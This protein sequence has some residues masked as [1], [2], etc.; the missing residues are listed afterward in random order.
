MRNIKLLLEYD[1]TEYVGWQI[2]DN[3]RSVQGELEHALSTVTQQ[4]VRL[5]G[6][7]RTDAGVHAR[8]QVAHFHTESSLSAEQLK[9]GVNALVADDLRVL[10]AQEVSMEFHARYSAKQRNYE[11]TIIRKP[12][13][14]LR[15]VSW[16]VSYA[17][18]MGAFLK[19]SEQLLGRRDF[20]SFCKNGDQR[21]N[22]VC[23]VSTARWAEQG[24]IL[25]FEIGA[26]RFVHGMVRA[27]VG[28]MID[29]ARGYL[30][31]AEFLKII[32]ARDR[33]A[34]GTSAPAQG[35]VLQSVE[36]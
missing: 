24:D 13:P 17:M 32:Q 1:G 19:C 29:V 10:D 36:Y 27:L 30:D 7:G 9:M 16:Y 25:R 3:G 35:L 6:A 23:S 15:R 33:K 12:H 11:Y 34:A 20:R 22:T 31:F 8:G 18:D 14:L 26:D 2:Q 21:E 28:T 4:P 5:I